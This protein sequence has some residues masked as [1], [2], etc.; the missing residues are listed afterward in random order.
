MLIWAINWDGVGTSQTMYVREPEDAVTRSR[1]SLQGV[2]LKC[3][4]ATSPCSASHRRRR[5]TWRL[6]SLHRQPMSQPATS[7]LE[8]P[9]ASCRLTPMDVLDAV[10][11]MAGAAEDLTPGTI[12][13]CWLKCEPILPAR[14]AATLKEM[15]AAL[16]PPTKAATASSTQQQPKPKKVTAD[17]GL[18]DLVARLRRVSLADLNAEGDVTNDPL[19]AV[20]KAVLAVQPATAEAAL[21]GWIVFDDADEVII[22]MLTGEDVDHVVDVCWRRRATTTNPTTKRLRRRGRRPRRRLPR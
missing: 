15:V 18:N 22:D 17:A 11:L 5:T 8:Q 3:T 7:T 13:S 10:R 12:A 14:H 6:F 21:K 20:V 4:Q 16:K 19:A 2:H 9:R 1:G